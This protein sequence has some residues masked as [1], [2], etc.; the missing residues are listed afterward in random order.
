MKNALRW[1]AV[2]PAGVAACFIAG[3][4]LHIFAVMIHNYGTGEN[5][6]LLNLHTHL[7]KLGVL[8]LK[9]ILCGF[10]L[11]LVFVWTG[12]VVAPTHRTTVAW[13]LAGMLAVALAFVGMMILSHPERVAS[14]LP[15]TIV[16][17]CLWPLGLASGLILTF[18]REQ[19]KREAAN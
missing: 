3:A 4:L 10:A 11:P 12:A 6:G 17:M 19:K 15:V 5:A 1:I 7:A 18:H 13:T 8:N 14:P 9:Q 16:T 2:L